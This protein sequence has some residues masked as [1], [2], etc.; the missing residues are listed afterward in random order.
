MTWCGANRRV[1]FEST[2]TSVPEVFNATKSTDPTHLQ[3]D[4]HRGGHVR[5]GRLA[6]G[7]RVEE[8]EAEDVERVDA[9]AP[10]GVA[11]L[12][13]CAERGKDC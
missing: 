11:G 9:R 6:G 3:D 13:L 8:Q 12:G 4:G 10:V 5:P 2:S 7:A 1:L